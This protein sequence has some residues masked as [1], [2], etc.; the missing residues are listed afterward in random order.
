MKYLSVWDAPVTFALIFSPQFT[1]VYSSRHL[2]HK[3]CP[4][5]VTVFDIMILDVQSG[6][7]VDMR[8]R[9]LFMVLNIEKVNP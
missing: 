9:Y 2:P 4:S 1:K 3:K 7:N 5:L 8:T 6:R